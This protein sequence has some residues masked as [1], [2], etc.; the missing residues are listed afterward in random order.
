VWVQSLPPQ[1]SK[2]VCLPLSHEQ[3]EMKQAS[4]F[5]AAPAGPLQYG[6]VLHKRIRITNES[7]F[8]QKLLGERTILFPSSIFP[9]SVDV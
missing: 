1:T 3:F 7:F 2:S 8:C 4:V 6:I 9:P 5:A